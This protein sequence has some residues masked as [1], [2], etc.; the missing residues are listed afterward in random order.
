VRS[1]HVDTFARDNLPP[2]E[3]WPEFCFDL[4]ELAYPERMNCAT[5]LLDDMVQ[6]G[7]GERVAIRAPDGECTYA[8]LLAQANR[9]ANVL[10]DLSESLYGIRVVTANNRQR[11]NIRNHRHVVGAY[12][13]ANLYT[14]RVN[15]IA[16]NYG[17][18]PAGPQYVIERASPSTSATNRSREKALPAAASAARPICSARDWSLRRRSAFRRA[19]ASCGGTRMPVSGVT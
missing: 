11:R 8:Q 13:D 19:G 5:V 18:L 9:I 1:A 2:R 3:Q 12:R 15:A 7:H 14:G 16:L 10:A 4:P 6:A 17:R